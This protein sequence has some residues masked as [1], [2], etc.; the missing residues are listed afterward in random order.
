MY[1][2]ESNVG[3]SNI[4]IDVAGYVVY[5]QDK[6]SVTNVQGYKVVID[7]QHGIQ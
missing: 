3:V 6:H 1:L 7:E 2:D 4:P 5:L